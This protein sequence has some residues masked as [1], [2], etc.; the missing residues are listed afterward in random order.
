MNI[1]TVLLLRNY[2]FNIFSIFLETKT[3]QQQSLIRKKIYIHRY[4]SR[5]CMNKQLLTVF[6]IGLLSTSL[7]LRLLFQ[8]CILSK[9]KRTSKLKKC[10][11]TTIFLTYNLEIDS[12]YTMSFIFLFWLCCECRMKSINFV[13]QLSTTVK[14]CFHQQNG[15]NAIKNTNLFR[16][17]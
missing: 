12:F 14:T 4:I 9:K 2:K 16:K 10:H 7:S 17:S 1:L 15:N 13:Q 8:Y 11:S 6:D 5:I 3:S